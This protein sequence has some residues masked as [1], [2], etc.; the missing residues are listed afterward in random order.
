MVKHLFLLAGVTHSV[1]F[2]YYTCSKSHGKSR[3][4]MVREYHNHTLQTN[5]LH[6]YR[7]EETQSTSRTMT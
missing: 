5:P 6:G 1:N 4:N 2:L 7:E 3:E